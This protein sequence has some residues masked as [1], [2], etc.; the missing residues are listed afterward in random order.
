[1]APTLTSKQIRQ[2]FLDFFASKDHAIVGSSPVVPLDDPTLMFTNAGM[3][4]F[5]DVFLSTGSRPYN[6]A[7]DTQK[8]IRAGGKHNDLDDVG[9]DTYHHTFF[10]MLG[11]WSFGDYFKKEAIAWAWELLTEVWGI[12][13][14]RL[15][16]TYFEG[17]PADGLEPDL[18]AAELWKT[19]T[20]IDPTHVHPGGKKD[21]FWEM[22]DTGPC[23]PCSEIHID[24]TPDKSGHALVNADDARVIELWN[25]VFI[26]F[27]RDSNGKLTPLPAKH[28][29][30]GMG[31][32]RTCAVLQGKKSNYDTDVW[33][34]IFE[35]IRKRTGAPAYAGTLPTDAD[36]LQSSDRAEDT[37][38][39]QSSDRAEDTREPRSSDRADSPD[40][41]TSRTEDPRGLKP[42]ARS[43]SGGVGTTD[44][45]RLMI[46]VSYRVIADHVRC[47][48][49]ALTDGAVPDRD[50]RGYVLRSILRRAVYH[51]RQY[52]NMHE[53]FLCDLVETVVDQM[54]DVFPGLRTNLGKRTVEYTAE[55]IRDEE[56]SFFKTLDRGI[57][58]FWSYAGYAF[59]KQ[60]IAESGEKKKGGRK[61]LLYVDPA[62]TRAVK[63]FEPDFDL[64][65]PET[66]LTIR[67]DASGILDRFE[68][69]E[70]TKERVRKYCENPPIITG[71]A[72]FK[73]H[74][75]YGFP[76]DLTEVMARERGFQ[77]DVAEFERLMEQAREKARQS[78]QR[79]V[80]SVWESLRDSPSS[81]EG[82]DR[83]VAALAAGTEFT[84]YDELD[85]DTWIAA[86]VP[87]R[88]DTPRANIGQPIEAGQSGAVILERT[89]FY[90][91]SGG[92]VGDSGEIVQGDSR[93]LVE[94]VE[95]TTELGAPLSPHSQGASFHAH[96]SHIGR[97]VHGSIVPGKECIAHVATS[98][99]STTKNHTATHM[100]N[101]ALR[102]VLGDHI[103][104]KGSLVDPEKTRFDFSHN[105]PMTV[106]QLR[107]VEAHVNRFIDDDLPVHVK[108]D[109]VKDDAI[110]INTLRA[111]FG[112]TYPD[113][114]RVISIGADVDEMLASPDD[115]KWMQ[116]PVEFCGG[117]HLKR[118]AEAERF[119]LISEEA[120]AKGVRRVVGI[121]GDAAKQAEAIG[122][123]LLE[124][125]KAFG[126]DADT[127]RGLQPARTRAHLG[128]VLSGFLQRVNEAVI[129]IRLRHEIREITTELQKEAKKQQKKAASASGDVVMDKV[130]ALLTSAETVGDVTVV[131]GEVPAAPVEALRG[132]IDWVRNKRG[133]SAVLLAMASDK[134]VTLVAGMSKDV[135]AKGAKA[136]DLIKEVAPLVGGKGG[137]RPD[138]A[139][140]G[141]S[142]PSGIPNALERAKAWINEK[143]A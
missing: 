117:T 54:S 100:L 110:K 138:M 27:N 107:E 102:E 18:E 2:Q 109:A 94:R 75:T 70:L 72:A 17:D 64:M 90:A 47:L 118:T 132:A 1:M 25:L 101:W 42:A 30:T 91:E 123:K 68:L 12:D 134:R 50:G 127:S 74:D 9:Q 104:Q 34:P 60:V 32:E 103:Q 76:I 55:L 141:G 57:D 140:G 28:V 142:D 43:E 99:H 38:E 77:V 59:W 4:Q 39:L 6:R 92:Q 84:G 139:Q 16:A 21:N 10:E 31:F 23:G 62:H 35:A 122:T 26:Q 81:F 66:T 15:H 45:E 131:V 61:D 113:R 40:S 143:L 33:T 115:K 48:T 78:S 108:D 37:R 98:R 125:A 129:P 65:D 96:V 112:E 8:C 67:G 119:V 86:T 120:V 88:R 137:G 89:P 130:R 46:D 14:T 20:D 56:S 13:R 95:R 36:E 126:G 7:A 87:T 82:S 41:G 83:Q 44:H 136:G 52:M 63:L 135:V 121:T 3:N 85:T 106:E 124:E 51:G 19:V 128:V 79:Q 133:S 73:L 49:F 114:V 5:K 24:L 53:P 111:V 71:E 105:K 22:G 93:F 69:S 29:D 11:N 58:T 97:T 80:D 116:Y